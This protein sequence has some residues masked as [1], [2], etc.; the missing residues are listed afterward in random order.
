MDIHSL[1]LGTIHMEG[2]A[3][4]DGFYLRG[5]LIGWDALPDAR[6]SLDAVPGADGSFEEDDPLRESRA[7][8]IAG[9]V[10]AGT[11]AEAEAMWAR[12][13]ADLK[14][15]ATLRV[16][17]ELGTLTAVVRVDA[18]TPTDPGPWATWIDFTIDLIAYDPV[19][20]RDPQFFGPLGLP[21]QS[22]GLFLPAVLPW[23]LGVADLQVAEVTNGGSLP[24]HPVVTLT[25]SASSVVVHGGPRRVSFG[26]FDGTLVFDS[27]QRR[28]F[29]NGADVT[30]QMVLRNWFE[31]PAGESQGFSFEAVS[32]SSDLYMSG[33][34]RIGVW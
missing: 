30:R 17:D 13:K 26:A 34:S 16:T 6:G 15:K 28:T 7:I 11:R 23:D 32:P 3:G 24:M 9:V 8:S 4:N 33:V 12:A 22:G 25:G 27:L 31:V 1:Q 21:V 18:M 5:P 29:L 19:R 14:R 10:S 2:G 20:Y